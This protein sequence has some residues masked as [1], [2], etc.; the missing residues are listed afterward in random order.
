M[1]MYMLILHVFMIIQEYDPLTE[2][3]TGIRARCKY[4]L[5]SLNKS[6]IN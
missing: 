6:D 4:I 1:L 2:K 3:K 5:F